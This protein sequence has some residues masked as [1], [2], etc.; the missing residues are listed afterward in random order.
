MDNL[1]MDYTK[2]TKYDLDLPNDLM[3][4]LRERMSELGHHRDQHM[5]LGPLTPLFVKHGWVMVCKN[6]HERSA[7]YPPNKTMG[8]VVAELGDW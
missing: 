6:N 5:H 7:L 2:A 4:Q 3:K 1:E 8:D